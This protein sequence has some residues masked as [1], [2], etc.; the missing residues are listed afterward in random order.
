MNSLYTI[1]FTKK[2]A[3]RLFSLLW[4]NGV[5]L[6]A[7]V[8]LNNTGQL[9][10]YTKAND[11]AFF[12]GLVGIQYQHWRDFAPTKDILAAYRADGDFEAYTAHYRELIAQMHAVEQLS[13]GVFASQVVCL[14]CSEPTADRCHR[15]LAA[16]LICRAMPGL[17]VRHL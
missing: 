16:E 10:G 6:L 14:L 12:L 11:L 7:D 4:A 1:G 2:S 5:T 8:R 3:E 17:Q 9:A 13:A 15:R